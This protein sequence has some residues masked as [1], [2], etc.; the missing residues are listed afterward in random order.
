MNHPSEELL[1]LLK[2][3]I[4]DSI[5]SSFSFR[6]SPQLLTETQTKD[7]NSQPKRLGRR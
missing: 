5:D 7:K 2:L 1:S 3:F 4:Y 6:D